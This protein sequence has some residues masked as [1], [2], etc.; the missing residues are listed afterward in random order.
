MKI[1]QVFIQD[2]SN[3]NSFQLD[4]TYPEGHPKAGNAL[5][6]V[7]LI[8]PNGVGKSRLMSV[9]QDYL[10]NIIRFRSK[11]LFIVKLQLEDSFIYSVHL[12]N[13]TLFFRD[14][15]DSEPQ[16][17]AELI[18]DQ[19]FTMAFNTNYE[20]FCIG[21]EEEPELF[22]ALW[23]DNNSNDV[24]LHLPA[25]YKD[26]TL[27]LTDV[28]MTKGHE[29]QSLRDTFPLFNEISPE[30]ITDF[31]ALLIFLIAK[32]EDA[33][34]DFI[35][36]PE[37]RNKPDSVMQQV[38]ARQYPGVLESLN[39][40]WGPLLKEVGLKLDLENASLPRHLKDRLQVYIVR[41]SDGERVDFNMLGT[42]LRRLL[43]NLGHS[44]ALFYQREID[45]AFI[46]LEE[47]EG[48]LH[49]NILKTLIGRY[50]D[51]HPEAQMFVSTHNP[52]IAASFDPSERLIFRK[53]ESGQLSVNRSEAPADADLSAIMEH[54]F[55]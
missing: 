25:D 2:L 39:E 22:E 41:E 29:A 46:L 4:L 54:D 11:T 27:L 10:R 30:K 20:Q 9:L 31:W 48:G 8:G 51:L 35:N 19:A 55:S 28:P 40:I 17:M 33:V 23:F 3:F 13:N 52:I 45:S 47:P 44:W 7:C 5:D 1:A 24:I 53:D 43:F 16:W 14:D 38:F 6:K 15:I 34:R 36:L 42:G 21:F 32:R 18:R 50:S 12:M 37:N 26:R 49:P